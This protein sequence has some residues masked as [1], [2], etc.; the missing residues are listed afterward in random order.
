ME[1]DAKRLRLLRMM[2]EIDNHAIILLDRQGYI[3][4][5]NKGAEK[6]KGYQAGEIINQ[7]FRIFYTEADRQAGL[8]S[9]LL[10][11]ATTAGKVYHEGWRL[12]KDGSRFWGAV[13]IVASYDEQGVLTG[14]AKITRDLTERV[15]AETTIKLH[16][17]NLEIQNKE[18]EQ[19]VYI[20]S[21]DL[22][23]PLLN[24]SNFAE[25]LRL[26]YG[27]KLDETAEMYLGVIRHC[28]HRMRDLI[29][30]LLD[31]SRIGRR[32]ALVPVDC[33]Q[34]IDMVKE[35]LSTQLR[36][37]GAVI[38]CD[39][40]PTVNAYA[41]ELRQLM[42]NLISNAIKFRATDRKPVVTISASLRDHHWQF[43]VADN[44][45]GINPSHSEK[46]FK[47]FQ[48][49]NDRDAYEGNGIGLAH[50]KKIVELHGGALWVES[51]PGQGSRFSF[52][53]PVH[54]L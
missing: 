28:T 14:F 17:Q 52:T 8:P 40:L 37:T 10:A 36:Q 44:G 6:I 33:Q 25:L 48:R 34:L 51:T 23:E 39:A 2:D 49:L 9:Q 35:D 46:I 7:N 41:I 31:Y 22:Q 30:D 42:Q 38:Q 32:K 50:C 13:T 1:L 21:H 15:D 11:E 26:E 16:A 53:I 43:T 20:A 27:D 18:L 19:F 54:T 29:K 3:E 45:I 24:I 5:W 47:I 12:R 4:T